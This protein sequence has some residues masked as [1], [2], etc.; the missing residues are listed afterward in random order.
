MSDDPAQIP[1]QPP[2]PPRHP[3]QDG[4]PAPPSPPYA[5]QP[6]T[7]YGPQPYAAQP[8]YAVPPPYPSSPYASQ[9]WTGYGPPVMQPPP[10]GQGPPL[11]LL[12]PP[13]V[14]LGAR[15]V[16]G[17]ILL[18]ALAVLAGGAGLVQYAVGMDSGAS[19]AVAVVIYAA[20]L[21]LLLG[22]EPYMTWRYGG[23]FGKRLFKLRVVRL[24][25]G[26]RLS[27]LRALG[28]YWVTFPMALV[29]FLGTLNVLWCCWDKP[30]RQCLH[31]KAVSSVVITQR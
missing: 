29:P 5:A 19:K 24:Q 14:R 20:L 2:T 15:L 9:P 3:P 28:R 18:L 22:Y 27:F 25:D 6:W 12:P 1:P 16:D 30:Y 11:S 10:P 17:V 7:G 26:E 13:G 4:H 31:D 23:T 8:P 21:A